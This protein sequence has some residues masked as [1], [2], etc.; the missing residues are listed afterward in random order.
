MKSFQRSFPA[1]VDSIRAFVIYWRKYGAYLV[2][3]NRLG[4]LCLLRNSMITLNDRPNM[5]ITVS[6]DVKQHTP[7]HTHI[8]FILCILHANGTLNKICSDAYP[9][10]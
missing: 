10:W 7:P 8:N 2:Q 9:T 4:G 5:T 6:V 1:S 3:V